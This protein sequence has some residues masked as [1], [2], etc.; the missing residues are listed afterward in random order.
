MKKQVLT[1]IASGIVLFANAQVKQGT[2]VALPIKAHKV[3]PAI[4]PSDNQAPYQSQNPNTINVPKGGGYAPGVFAVTEAIAGNT[5]YDLQTNATSYPRIMKHSDGTMNVTWTIIPDGGASAQRGTGYN[6]WDGSAW[7][8]APTAR[9]EPASRTGFVNLYTTSTG[10]EGSMAHSSTTTSVLNCSRPTKG[11]GTWAEI[12][13]TGGPNS[14]TWARVAVGGTDGKTIHFIVNKNDVA[15]VGGGIVYSRS[16]DEGATWGVLRTQIPGLDDASYPALFG[17]DNYYIAAS[18]TTVAVVVGDPNTDI[19]LFKSTDNGDTW[20]KTILTSNFGTQGYF[21]PDG[22]ISDTNGDGVADTVLSTGGDVHCVIDGSGMV[23]VAWGLMR[24]LDDDPTPGNTS[25]NVFLSTNGINYWKEGMSA[26]VL[27]AQSDDWNGNGFID[28]A[29]ELDASC[30]ANDL[31]WG[32]YGNMGLAC[33]PTLAVSGSNVFLGYQAINEL[34][35]TTL[36]K[37]SHYQTFISSSSDG[38]MTWGIGYNVMT[39]SGFVDSSLSEGAFPSLSTMVDA[40]VYMV[41]QRD[42]APGHSLAA[43]ACDIANNDPSANLNDIVVASIPV[44]DLVG[45]NE[46]KSQTRFSVSQNMPNPFSGVSTFTLSTKTTGDVTVEITNMLGSVVSTKTY[47]RMNAGNHTLTLDAT[48]LLAG[49]YYYVV[50]MGDGQV[51][52]KMIVK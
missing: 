33:I 2:P 1:L 16:T 32:R 41:Y 39:N 31:N 45:I 42:Y 17:G 9:I 28:A 19:V 11:S 22:G 37:K 6:Y 38:G 30:D 26:P 40:N 21:N 15:N 7:G 34:A 52:N 20:V 27:A 50:K 3:M 51:T 47:E 46:I 35:D 12:D 14:D 44:S 8:A 10:M 23:H 18:G 25:F 43:G 36:Y 5:D 4:K 49:V 29:T 13:N 24:I 48:N